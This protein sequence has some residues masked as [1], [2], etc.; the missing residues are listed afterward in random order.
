MTPTSLSLLDRLRHSPTA[1]DW[2]RVNDVYRQLIRG[3]LARVPGIGDEID[4]LTQEV[5]FVVYREVAGFER[6][7]EGSFR[8]WLRRIT[9]NRVREYWRSKAK[10]PLVG[11]DGQATEDFLSNLDDA[12]SDLSQQ[13]DREHDRH[14]LDR[15]LEA[16]R[17]DF[18]PET[19]KAFQ[20][21]ALDGVPAAKVAEEMRTTENAVVLAKSRIL[22]RLRE[23]AGALL[24]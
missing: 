20:R 19:W 1:A 2:N 9:V 22:S 24:E 17:D 21:F 12:T 14:V 18:K 13:W 23:E 6:Q 8:T 11:L 16:V 10:R 5:L 7:R 15:L 3:W 4:D